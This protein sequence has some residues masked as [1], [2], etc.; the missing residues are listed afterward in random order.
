MLNFIKTPKALFAAAIFGLEIFGLGIFSCASAP[1]QDETQSQESGQ[2]QNEAQAQG[3]GA[4]SVQVQDGTQEIFLPE[5]FEE[6]AAGRGDATFKTSKPKCAL[7]ING[8]YHGLTPLKA[9]G[10]VPGRYAVQIKKK[11]FKTVNIAIQV[12]DGISDFYYIEM[13]VDEPENL[14]L[15]QDKE[16]APVPSQTQSQAAPE[17]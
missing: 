7:Y 4:A 14:E 8:E 9:A 12:K 2:G 6:I 15:S 10:L 3:V 13:E 11:G 17:L 5:R 16:A 1:V